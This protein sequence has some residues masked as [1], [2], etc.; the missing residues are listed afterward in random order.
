MKKIVTGFILIIITA[1]PSN[2]QENFVQTALNDT[3]FD[4]KSVES[5]GVRIHYQEGSF[6]EKHRM[7]LLRSVQSAIEE[8]L[9]LLDESPY[10]RTIQVFYL[11][12]R[13]EMAKIIGRTYAGFTDWS[14]G[15]IFL[16]F[17]PE[18][19]SFE[20]H[21]LMHLFTMGNWGTPDVTSRWMIEGISVFSDGWCREY[22]VDEVAYFFLSKDEL[23]SLEVLFEN[24]TSL[25][26]IK[27]GFYAASVIGFIK[28]KYGSAA[29][30][31]LW[32]NGSTNFE[33]LL[34]DDMNRLETEW[35]NYL[36]LKIKKEIKID[37][38]T[39]NSH[40]CG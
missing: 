20:K 24:F 27:G 5:E 36:R 22:S 34:G 1:V 16:V 14:S 11:N 15:G 38:D 2:G 19:R 12:S 35:K 32:I 25:G 23:P 39:I 40:G 18:W 17:N 6:A 33:N 30:R 29:L 28:Q 26:E 10:D 3:S 21:E 13:E 37:L 7:M 4:W 9:D 31:N 8:I